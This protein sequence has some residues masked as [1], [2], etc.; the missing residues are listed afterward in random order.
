MGNTDNKIKI[1]PGFASIVL[2][3]CLFAGW[4]TLLIV[5]VLMFFFCDIDEKVKQVAV[6]VITFYVGLTIVSWGFDIIIKIATLAVDIINNIVAYLITHCDAD[7]EIAFLMTPLGLIIKCANRVFEILIVLV[8]L[9]FIIGILTGSPA[10]PN[11]LTSKINEYVN[12]ALN[13]VNGNI[14]ANMNM[15]PMPNAPMGPQ[16]QP[17]MPSQNM[18]MPNNGM[19][20]PQQMPNPGQ[21][22]MGQPNMGGT[23][24]PNNQNK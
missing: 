16:V 17:N 24:H 3:A 2:V 21:P 10:K 22:N 5:T 11:P 9:G 4:Q 13:Y 8:K 18:G 1:N 6:S 15:Q 23:I 14:G 19:G 7:I 12:K 20:M